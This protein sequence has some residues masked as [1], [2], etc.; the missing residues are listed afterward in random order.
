MFDK[1]TYVLNSKVR[2]PES[3][4]EERGTDFL[5]S[6]FALAAFYFLIAYL[7]ESSTPFVEL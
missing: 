7:E 6:N 4:L 2:E 5:P 3:P 1:E